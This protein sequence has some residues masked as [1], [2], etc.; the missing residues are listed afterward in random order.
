[1]GFIAVSFCQ[2]IRQTT[3]GGLKTRMPHASDCGGTLEIVQIFIRASSVSAQAPWISCPV[4]G[5]ENSRTTPDAL[6]IIYK[7]ITKSNDS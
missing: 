2:R 3:T 5:F 6:F 7:P 1:M 4:A